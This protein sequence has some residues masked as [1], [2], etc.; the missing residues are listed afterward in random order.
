[1]TL[2]SQ[3][4]TDAAT[5]FCNTDEFA[6]TVTYYPHQYYGDTARDPR[7]ISA[8]VFRQSATVINEDGGEVVRYIYEVHVAN[9]SDVGIA[10]DELDLGGDQIELPP[11]DGKDAERKA[12]TR[13]MFQDN[14]MLVLEC[15]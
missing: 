11:R 9:D 8:V 12:V 4:N 7:T 14:G 5:I 2:R 13:L 6:E 10:S 1:M 3:I 15:Q